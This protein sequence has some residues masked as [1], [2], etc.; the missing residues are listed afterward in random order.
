MN[1]DFPKRERPAANNRWLMSF[2]DLL[3]LI[4]TFFVMLYSMTDPIQINTKPSKNYNSAVEFKDGGKD[5]KIA[6]ENP[7]ATVD[8]G[9][10]ESVIRDKI[11]HDDGMKKLHVKIINDKLTVYADKTSYTDQTI[12]A[13]YDTI[14][15]LSSVTGVVASDLA[16]ARDVAH[17]FNKLGMTDNLTYFEDNNLQNNVKILIYSKF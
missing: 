12:K 17:K 2:A 11:I 3:S 16:T 10:I 4:L 14:T 15:P 13:L 6:L 5:A 8:N 7:L 9:Y 1:F